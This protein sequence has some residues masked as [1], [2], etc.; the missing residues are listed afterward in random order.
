MKFIAKAL[1]VFSFILSVNFLSAQSKQLLTPEVLWQFG[2]VSLQDISP[3]GKFI[4]YG[5]RYY[6]KEENSG[7]TDL[8][9]L[10][11][12][13][14]R[15]IQLT[16]SEE[17]EYNARFTSDGQRIGFLKKGNLYEMDLKG[18]NQ[19]LVSEKEMN[20]FAYAPS[21]DGLLFIADVKLEATAMDKHSD[22][23]KADARIMDDLMYRHWN[24]WDDYKKS[25]IHYVGYEPGKIS[26]ETINIMDGPYDSPVNPF[27]G[28]EQISFSPD[29]KF[30]AYTSKKV[31]G[32]A[33][34][35]STNTDIYLYDIQKKTT[36]NLTKG[37]MGYDI[38]PSFSVDGKYLLWSSMKRDGYEAD[39]NRI[40]R[41]DLNAKEKIELTTGQE[42][43]ANS[44]T[45]SS[46]GKTVYFSAA[47]Q[48]TYQLF[49]VDIATKQVKQLTEGKHNY[50]DFVLNEKQ[51]IA[52]RASMS[53]PH[54]LYKVNIADGQAKQMTQINKGLLGLVKMGE[55]KERWIKT[56]DGKDMLIWM[57][58]PPDFDPTKKYPA[59]LYCQGGPQ[60]TVSQFWSY[61][62]NFQMMAANGYVVVAPNRR[63]LPSFGRQWNEDISGDW[64]GQA[65]KDLLSAIDDAKQESYIDENRL[66]AVGA[67]YGGYSTYWLAG[68]HKKRFKTF[69][70]HGGLFN[71]ESWYG[72]TEELFFANWDLKG[73]YWQSPLPE[74]YKT[75]SPHKFVKNWDTPLLVIH[76]GK[77]FRVPESEGMQAFQAAQL[78]GVPSRFLYFPNEGH[79]I[80]KPQ[81]GILWQR[82]FFD[83]LDRSLK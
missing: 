75:D 8:F 49:K 31:N 58:Y 5:V 83:W 39:R 10:S 13:N 9:L 45:L 18:E 3:D 53:M 63:G 25:Q 23:P 77:D 62:W 71:L 34:A 37:M 65:M 15:P 72:T 16:K 27:G 43:S 4:I 80:L 14:G 2:R 68:N 12:T 40:F 59:I 33:F 51:I 74:T 21:G 29:G 48:G 26:R 11:T 66:G 17:S 42:L 60:S 69:I 32:K 70:A 22:L 1:L 78:K 76:G 79:W 81:N 38:E 56:T 24:T 50:Y 55:V 7:S 64:G 44:P 82:V 35:E 47:T 67:S 73:P 36:S 61:R 20:G 19:K 52:R 30:I 57:I 54:E 46:D 28:M 6:S 41:M